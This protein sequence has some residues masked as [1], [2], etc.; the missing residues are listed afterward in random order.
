MVDDGTIFQ[1]N[2]KYE[3]LAP[4]MNE[5]IRRYW[6]VSEA[7]SLGWGGVSVVSQATGLSRTTIQTGI[8]ELRKPTPSAT[9][10]DQ[11]CACAFLEQGANLWVG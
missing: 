10:V 1:I 3:A 8:R 5:K 11:K 7:M 4:I 6:A 2:T 9:A